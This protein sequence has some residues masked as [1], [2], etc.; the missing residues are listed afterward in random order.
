MEAQKEN[1]AKTQAR[2]RGAENLKVF[3]KTQKKNSTVA[4]SNVDFIAHAFAGC[5]QDE[6]PW[7]AGFSGDGAVADHSVWFGGSALPLPRFIRSDHNNYIATSTFRRGVDGQFRRRKDCWAGMWL[8]LHDDLGTKIPFDKLRLEPSC[9]IETSPGNFQGWLFLVAP[10]R[11]QQRAEA[12][13][14][15]IIQAEAN[16][17]GAG[18]ITRYG[19]LPVG[20]NGKGKYADKAGKP[21]VQRVHAWQPERRYSAEEVAKAYGFDLNAVT[22][23]TVRRIASKTT[24]GDNGYISI[25]DGAGLY[26]EGMRGM[27]GHRIICPW[28]SQHTG[29]D[30][31]GTVFFEPSEENEWRGGFVCHHGHCKGRNIAD[32]DYFIQRLLAGRAA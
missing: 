31:T 20:V 19:R 27:E 3:E 16:D 26:L 22:R 12:L 4:V 8:I 1:P 10:E 15:G 17:P 30:T 23:P 11:N 5:G 18:N 28:H 9:L 14:N 13:I 2:A 6:A 29:E 21:W 24:H 7:C 25:L 32:L